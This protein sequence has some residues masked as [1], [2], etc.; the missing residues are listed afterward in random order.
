M[1]AF[2]N[3][4]FFRNSLLLTPAL[5][6]ALTLAA[7]GGSSGASKNKP[8]TKPTTPT[9]QPGNGQYQSELF[10]VRGNWAIMDGE[11]TSNIVAQLN[12]L[13][14]A[15]PQV[16]TIV[17]EN[18]PGSSDDEANLKAGL[19]L[20]ELGLNT[21]IP[22]GG[23]IA[24]GG[25]D[26]FLAGKQRFAAA[27]V[28]VGVHSWGAE[29]VKDASLLG[30]DHEAHQLYLDYYRQLGINS[31]FYWFT[32]QAAD[33]D[34]IHWMSA[35]ER[36]QYGLTSR[37]ASPQELAMIT[38][39]ATD[40]KAISALFDK[41]TWV[42]SANNQPIH[43]FATEEVS[44]A[45]MQKARSVMQHYLNNVAGLTNKDAI[46]NQLAENQASLFIFADE[47]AS[48]AAFESQL[49]D[50]PL[51]QHG[52]DLY[53]SEI[54]VEG[55][56]NYRQRP[57]PAGRDATYEEVLHLVQGFG[58]AA[59]K[60]LQ[61]KIVTLADQA[62]MD[63]VWNPEAD[64]VTE[65]RNEKGRYGYDSVSFEYLASAVEGYYGLWGHSDAGMDG[66]LGTNRQRQQ[67]KDPQGQ[68][69]IESLWPGYLVTPMLISDQLGDNETF[70]LQFDASLPY[71]HQS[72][73]LLAARLTG[74]HN[75]HL[76]GNAG[77][78]VLQ[79]NGG[80]N[81][82]NGGPAGEDVAVFQGL[83]DEYEV[84]YEAGYWQISDKVANRD[85]RDS[86][87]NIDI[88]E[89]RDVDLDTKELTPSVK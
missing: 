49:K 14:R 45:Q 8:V 34:N 21:F 36:Q 77:N 7:C 40:D 4:V 29:G 12:E 72:Q 78:N 66:Y 13:V 5:L 39:P 63:K 42:N 64:S 76:L 41:Y 19:R 25:V 80:N 2:P 9:T 83:I 28:L 68:A 84:Y 23:A 11:I 71:T 10:A 33:A 27:D 59:D 15:N 86:L 74:S 48:Q 6:S 53:A 57:N 81:I 88:I 43:I 52:Q 22:P 32:I 20:R 62:L 46:S 55:D 26:L 24:S 3:K 56:N 35:T 17:F 79:G 60:T 82:L 58:I 38:T 89:F 44:A 51:A 1:T 75:S 61:Q 47:A 30:R 85:G 73:Y 31:D 18:V 69:L 37:A 54:F 16:N 70:S 50:S 87:I 65:W 67:E